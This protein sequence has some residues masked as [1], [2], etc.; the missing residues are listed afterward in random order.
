MSEALRPSGDVDRLKTLLFRSEQEAIEDLRER[1]HDHHERIGSDAVMQRS[2]TRVLAGSLKD[3]RVRQHQQVADAIAPILVEGMKREIRNSRDEMVDALYPILGRLVSAYVSAAVADT[4]AATNHRLES[5]LTGRFLYLRAKAMLTGQ[6]YAALRLADRTAFA[7]REVMLIR[8]GAGTLI[9]HIVLDAGPGMPAAEPAQKTAE[10]VGKGQLGEVNGADSTLVSGVVAA[11]HDFAQDAFAK[12]NASLRSVDMG[13]QTIYL[14]ATSG[15]ILAVIGEGRARRKFER[16]LDRELVMLLEERADDI[17]KLDAEGTTRG[18]KILPAVAERLT[19]LQLETARGRPILA[20]LFFGLIAAAIAGWLGMVGLDAYRTA[21]LR[22]DVE[23]VIAED[24][25]LAGYPLEV[26]IDDARASVQ[27]R[28]FVPSKAVGDALRDRLEVVTD[29]VPVAAEFTPVP[30]TSGL[31]ERIGEA[32]ALLGSVRTG[33]DT[34]AGGQDVARL[35]QQLDD[36]AQALAALEAET[37]DVRS[38]T[39]GVDDALDKRV[40]AL[41]AA[42][43]GL[44]PLTAFTLQRGIFFSSDTTYRDAAKA[45]ETLRRLAELLGTQERIRIVGYADQRGQAA[46]NAALA[47]NRARTVADDLAALGV[48]RSRIVVV[49]R[50]DERLLSPDSGPES[51][52]RRV[53]FER[54]LAGE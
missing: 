49:E 22:A 39:S 16:A 44:D 37:A 25:A 15:L 17:A 42:P 1:I 31:A 20:F 51:G 27:V 29:G 53:E 23:R 6:S 4:M 35:R 8:R 26:A 14:R 41:E 36:V 9:D 47:L 33:L 7:I 45:R 2:V 12:R 40:A 19:T 38:R 54:V 43:S 28:G 52:N 21:N 13:G 10:A 34:R 32:E 5:G 46:R 3:A 11:I 24:K 30:S 48:A 18:P 50:A